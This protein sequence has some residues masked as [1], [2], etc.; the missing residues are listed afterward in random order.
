MT[1]E[2]FVDEML[3]KDQSFEWHRK[4]LVRFLKMPEEE[5]RRI[6]LPI[7]AYGSRN[8]GRMLLRCDRMFND[9]NKKEKE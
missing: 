8:V 1:P 5:R 9:A 4:F 3:P 2:E 6:L 7:M